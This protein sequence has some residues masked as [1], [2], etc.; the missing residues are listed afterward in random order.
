MLKY[1]L[2]ISIAKIE[3]FAKNSQKII[4]IA[5]NLKKIAKFML[6]Y[7]SIKRLLI[8]NAKFAKKP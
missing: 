6:K 4:K 8:S 2:K 3:K 1:F 7:F 5:K